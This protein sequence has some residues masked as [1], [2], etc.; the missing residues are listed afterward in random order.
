MRKG[1]G[2]EM[3]VTE[4]LKNTKAHQVYRLSDGTVAPG[5][6]TVL[7]I[8][9]KPALVPWANRLGLEG[10][11]VRSYVDKLASIG[12]LAHYMVECDLKD[13]E[14]DLSAYSPEE[15]NLA[16]NCLIKYWGWKEKNKPKP[17][18]IE[19]QLVSNKWRFGGTID[20]YC[21]IDNELWLVDLKTGKAI[22]PEM[23]T[24]L[25]AYTMLLKENG[26][27]TKKVQILRIGRSEDEGFE[28]NEKSLTQLKPHWEKFKHCLEIYR[29]DKEIRGN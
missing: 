21:E 12:T 28:V 1:K 10:I 9:A 7:N 6:T 24:Q 2:T 23:I 26:Y 11:D 17:I 4:K 5:V 16:E 20:L 14:P 25:S 22:Y 8:L 3:A 18:L 19:A 13:E 27:P 29:L 15:I